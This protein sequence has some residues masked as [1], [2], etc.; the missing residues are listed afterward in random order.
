MVETPAQTT[1]K[2]RGIGNRIFNA[3]AQRREGAKVLAKLH[4]VRARQPRTSSALG[5][6]KTVSMN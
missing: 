6:R 5:R 4:S 1:L 3:K 2:K